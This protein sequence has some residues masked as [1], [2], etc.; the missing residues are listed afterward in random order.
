MSNKLL[1]GEGLKGT[2]ENLS[3]RGREL[4]APRRLSEARPDPAPQQPRAPVTHSSRQRGGQNGHT[5]PGDGLGPTPPATLA[6]GSSRRPPS[7]LTGRLS[8]A[9]HRNGP[10][11][12][13]LRAA[14]LCALFRS[15]RFP[16]TCPLRHAVVSRATRRLL[17]TARPGYGGRGPQRVPAHGQRAGG[18]RP[19][20]R[21]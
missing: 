6:W 2:R 17:E 13:R 19:G 12:L 1:G 4:L 9:S 14:A 16:E 21:P 3:T 7:R 20:E 18:E 10:L 11:R 5:F 15:S 8:P